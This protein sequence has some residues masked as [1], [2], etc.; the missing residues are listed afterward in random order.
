M[1]VLVV[2]TSL[3]FLAALSLTSNMRSRTEAVIAASLIWNALLVGPIYILGLAGWLYRLPLAA[4]VAVP[5]L[6]IIGLDVRANGA[7]S[8]A[9]RALSIAM[10]PFAGIF[11]A[12][13]RRS[14]AVVGAV[15]ATVLFPYQLLCAYLAPTWRDWDGLW[16]HEPLTGY[17]IQNH[18][19]APV[20]L[21]MQLQYINGVHRLCEGTQTWFAIWGGRQVVDV[22][23]V[24]FMPLLAASMFAIARRYSNDVLTAIAWGSAL[25]LFRGFLRL[26]QTTMV[27]PQ[28]CALLLAAAYWVTDHK[29]DR[30]KSVIAILALTLAVGAKIWSIVPVGLL[31]LVLLV[32]IVRR[33]RELGGP[34]TAALVS[35]GTVSLLAM[36]SVTYLRN[37]LHFKNPL[38]PVIGYENK[39]LGINWP[40]LIQINS[41]ASRLGV[42][43]N[44][45]IPVQYR[46]ML[47]LPYSVMG[48]GHA[49]QADDWTFPYSWVVFPVCAV[50]VAVL[51]VRWLLVFSNGLRSRG[52]GDDAVWSA[53]TLA[54]VGI[55]SIYLSPAYHIPRYHTA[56]VG[57]IVA[58]L[59]WIS[60]RRSASRIALEVAIVAQLGSIMAAYWAPQRA[61]WISVYSPMQ[62]VRWLKTPMPARE[63]TDLTSKEWPEMLISPVLKEAGLARERDVRKGDVVAFDYTDFP[64]VLWNNAYSNT[65]VWLQSATDPLGEAEQK[66]AI[67][68]YTR[69]G[70]T[71]AGQ[72]ATS[73][74]WEQVGR[75][76]TENTGGIVWR[77]KQR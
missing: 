58:S 61:G 17:A 73:K 30:R 67:W 27:D 24:M 19:F 33:R 70:T 48:K 59:C 36:Q 8:L 31:A 41:K 51:T 25:V 26:L 77:K 15:A 13:R 5:S 50:A 42:D 20:D 28:A 3:A 69:P 49:W 60:S 34:A 68:L 29:L 47:E 52:R 12:W 74:A 32:R 76:E 65:V 4:C 2:L 1:V 37:W 54:F 18:G 57:M 46:K 53:M 56:A 21:P 55:V 9:R 72:L 75:L 14:L 64:A 62:V 63:V 23:N 39:T 22:A 38:W 7:S 66:H 35:V 6:V 44:E 11:Y 16:Y 45:P 43:F 71:L 10:L 40:G